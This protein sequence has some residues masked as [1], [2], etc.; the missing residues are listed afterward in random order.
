MLKYQLQPFRWLNIDLL[1]SGYLEKKKLRP[2]QQE[3]DP[4][5]QRVFPTQKTDSSYSGLPAKQNTQQR[6]CSIQETDSSYSGLSNQ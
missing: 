1:L 6:V 5:E 3:I 2:K 4:A